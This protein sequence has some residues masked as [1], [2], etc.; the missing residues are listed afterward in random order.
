MNKTEIILFILGIFVIGVLISVLIFGGQE[1]DYNK[2]KLDCKEI[3][4]CI[5]IGVSCVE[6][7]ITNTFLGM[8]W[9]VQTQNKANQK[10]Y[11]KTNCLNFDLLEKIR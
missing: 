5:I 2:G 4:E 9:Y 11:Y 3:R 6:T 1:Y 10:E 8:T 7:E